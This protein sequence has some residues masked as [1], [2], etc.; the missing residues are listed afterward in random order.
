[1]GGCDDTLAWCR[2]L[3]SPDKAK[4]ES[5]ESV[6]V[7]DGHSSDH[8]YDYDLIVIGGG[9]GGLA[10]SKEASTLG[11]KVAL[12]DYVK[13][14]PLGTKW[15]LGGTCVNVGC[16]PKK[17]MHYGA[18]INDII[19]YD[20]QHFGVPLDITSSLSNWEV[21]RENIQN[22]IRGLNFKYRVSLREKNVTY[23]NKLGRFIDSHTLEVTDKKGNKS[24]LTASRFVVSVGGRPS[25][26]T[27]PGGELAISSDDL[28][29]LEKDPGKVLCVG[30]SYVSLE[31]AGFLSAL[32]HD[33]TVA[34][35][36]IILRGYDRECSELIGTVMESHGVKL[37]RGVTPTFLEKS[38][39]K[40]KVTFSDD[41]QD[42]FDTVL[43]AIGRTADTQKLGLESI[44]VTTDS[45]GKLSTK[46]EQTSCPNVYAVGDVVQEGHELSPVA[47][48]SGRLLAQRLFGGVK[49]PFDYTNVCT[50]VF[51][52]IEYSCVGY[53]E[54]D[55]IQKFGKDNLDIYI[56]K[57][58]PLEW[59]L[60][61]ARA[62]AG[63]AEAFCKVIVDK[64]S[65]QVLG[66]HYV[67]PNAGEVMQGYG[68]S[69]SQRSL[70]LPMLQ[71]T[72]GIHPTT[73]EEILSMTITKESGGDASAGGC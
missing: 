68:V 35:R 62:Q 29:S 16:I 39:G 46:Y 28:F 2:L 25:P 10:L 38:E 19:R 37:K 24:K 5:I 58:I 12:L 23:L 49:K 31:C 56:K 13:P 48:Q 26:L 67:G 70:T 42:T 54:E 33:T 65:Q 9:S 50:T 60:S 66:I 1:L 69:M 41:S 40:I 71:N 63:H 55:A 43:V 44:G 17:L 73:A 7:D 32:G 3:C 52:P 22:Y 72:V 11:A 59:S 57:F 34:I 53:S 15:G 14:S 8:K 30:A 4:E 18:T 36:S 51:T 64:N 6:M 45:K 47:I 20:S 27:C 61:D 21:M